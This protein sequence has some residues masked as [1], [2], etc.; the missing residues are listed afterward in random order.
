MQHSFFRFNVL[1]LLL[2]VVFPPRLSAASVPHKA[3]FTF[4]ELN[5]RSGVLFAGRAAEI[6]QKIGLDA[7][8]VNVRQAAGLSTGKVT[9]SDAYSPRCERNMGEF[10]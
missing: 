9:G 10:S 3:I 8:V 7:T 1:A 6:F 4:G 5:K 2:F